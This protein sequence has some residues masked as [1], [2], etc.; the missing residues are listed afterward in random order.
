MY[1]HTLI[2]KFMYIYIY[3]MR[4]QKCSFKRVIVCVYVCVCVY[5]YVSDFVFV[6]VWYVRLSKKENTCPQ[7]FQPSAAPPRCLRTCLSQQQRMFWQ[8]ICSA[9]KSSCVLVQKV[10]GY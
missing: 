2:H 8:T 7:P 9:L 10:C 6:Y 4:T 3:M 5:F 1:A